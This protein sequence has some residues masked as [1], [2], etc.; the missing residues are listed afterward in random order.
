MPKLTTDYMGLKLKN[1]IIASSSGLTNSIEDIVELEKQ[2]V[3]AIVLKS[4]FEEEII[5]EAEENMNRMLSSGF[6]YPETFDYFEYD[7]MKDPVANY[8]KLIADA[9]KETSIPI[10]AS[11]NCVSSSKWPDF[12]KRIEDAGADAIELNIFVLPTDFDVCPG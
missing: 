5:M 6:V 10:I 11:V 4:L 1:P 12:A 9:K 3:G 7:D 8:L 2:G